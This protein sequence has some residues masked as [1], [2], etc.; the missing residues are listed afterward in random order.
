[1]VSCIGLVSGFMRPKSLK[2]C[3]IFLD[4]NNQPQMLSLCLNWMCYS[5]LALIALFVGLPLILEVLTLPSIP[6]N[7]YWVLCFIKFTFLVFLFL[8][9][10]TAGPARK[11]VSTTSWELT[12]LPHTC[13]YAPPLVAWENVEDIHSKLTTILGLFPELRLK[14]NISWK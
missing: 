13:M 3:S 11:T 12:W 1:M 8:A 7:S 2:F 14:T 10:Q 4:V 9:C 5:N 6:I